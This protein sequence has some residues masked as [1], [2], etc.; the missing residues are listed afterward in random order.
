MVRILV[1][2]LCC[3]IFTIQGY[4]IDS[5]YNKNWVKLISGASNQ[6]L[7]VIRNM[8]YIYAL[9]GVDCIDLCAN[10]LVTYAA[11]QG[12][13]NAQRV[14]PE[15]NPLLMISINDG[16]DPHFRKAV[17]DPNLCPP[18]CSRP[19]EKVCPAGAIPDASRGVISDRCYGCG[20]CINVCPYDQ[21]TEVPYTV[22]KDNILSLL[23][24]N[25]IKGVEIHT[26]PSN[27]SLFNSL[28]NSVGDEILN[29]SSVVSFSI[30]RVEDEYTQREHFVDLYNTLSNSSQFQ[31]YRG[32]FIWQA[33]GIAMS[34]DL[35]RSVVDSSVSFADLF[36]R[37]I[38][39]AVSLN[40]S[41]HFVQ[42]AG[43][44]NIHSAALVRERGLDRL[45]GFGG[46]AFGSFARR[47]IS[48]ELITLDSRKSGAL[49]E[50]YP[51]V[52]DECMNFAQNLV[53]SVKSSNNIK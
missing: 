36:M 33:D 14:S 32:V 25:L 23:K 26:T 45:P 8:C 5:L 29:S 27:S 6:N 12:I 40:I 24:G 4:Y 18:T 30:P 17:F 43:G 37:S 16:K 41:K 28:W 51:E 2:V 11:R 38:L 21:I 35:G 39:P 44:T 1:F 9:A 53:N 46:Y 47:M 22:E 50:K 20:R 13:E 7:P 49:V 31:S 42:L 34:G 3:F 15:V 52:L 48:R 19:C 10:S